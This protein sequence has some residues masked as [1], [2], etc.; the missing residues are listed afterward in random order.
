MR[1]GGSNSL[2]I[3]GN[4]KAAEVSTEFSLSN[5]YL[6]TYNAVDILIY[7]TEGPPEAKS[8]PITNNHNALS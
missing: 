5:S 3:H 8:L 4:L 7:A 2:T 6:K 1:K